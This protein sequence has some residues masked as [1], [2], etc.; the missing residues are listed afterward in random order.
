MKKRKKRNTL[1]QKPG[2]IKHNYLEE[3]NKKKLKCVRINTHAIDT[4]ACVCIFTQNI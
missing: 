4:N 1:L 2:I 3:N